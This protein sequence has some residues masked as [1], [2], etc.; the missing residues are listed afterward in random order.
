MF[1]LHARTT[2]HSHPSPLL[3]HPKPSPSSPTPSPFTL[4]S[5]AQ[6]STP[7]CALNPLLFNGHLQTIW[8]AVRSYDI[9]IY[10][11][12]YVFSA[13]DPAFA[14][15]FAVDFVVPPYDNSSPDTTLPPRTTYYQKDEYDA[16]GGD[17][18]KPMLVVLHGLS[19]G[20]HEIYLRAVLEP[21]VKAGWEACVVNS[22]GCA[23]SKITTGVLYNA[24]ATW[25]IR[26]VVL[27]CRERWPRRGLYGIG[28]SLGANIMVNVRRLYY[29]Y[30]FN[31]DR[32]MQNVDFICGVQYLGEEGEG[33][34]LNA[35]VVASNPWNLDVGAIALQRS[36]IGMEIYSKTMGASMKKL[37]E[38]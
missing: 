33:C 1:S 22:R 35:A 9:P 8:T 13:S 18:E 15:T 34:L 2:F 21:L 24:R 29:S 4:L 3:L 38:E 25:D 7:P 20:S 6:S 31:W 16:L 36:W 12:R 27:W 19:G 17:D 32:R 11:K 37:F 5:L 28:F 26:Q 23:M 30:N 14:G 10:Y